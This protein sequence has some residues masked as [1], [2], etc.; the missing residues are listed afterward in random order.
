MNGLGGNYDE[1]INWSQRVAQIVVPPTDNVYS[2][3]FTENDDWFKVTKNGTIFD[4]APS[5][6]LH[7]HSPDGF[8]WGYAGSGPTQLALAL[9]FDVTGDADLSMHF[10]MDYKWAV[11][12]RLSKKEGDIWTLTTTDILR[13]LQEKVNCQA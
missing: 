1:A 10:Y 13:W 2:G 9:L 6:K 12:A 8:A 7:N 4:H 5:L 11:T 3:V